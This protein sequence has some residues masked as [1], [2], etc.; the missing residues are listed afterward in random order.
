MWVENLECICVF[1]IAE[2]GDLQVL[3]LRSVRIAQVVKS[4]RRLGLYAAFGPLC[5][6]IK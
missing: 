3:I 6:A 5:N 2:K 1:V 4:D